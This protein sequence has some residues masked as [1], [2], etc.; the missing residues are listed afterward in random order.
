MDG[1]RRTDP[2][3]PWGAGTAQTGREERRRRRSGHG[4]TARRHT[5]RHPPARPLHPPAP[6]LEALTA[7]EREV[8]VLVARGLSNT[9]ICEY[10]H[11]SSGTVKTHMGR[12]LSKL[13]ARDRA[14]LVISAYE[15]GLVHA[16]RPSAPK[17]G[18]R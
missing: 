3:G 17:P 2:F 13:G 12:L 7:R 9:D 10:L 14:Q 1:A 8:L 5:S 11:L 18:H 15:S 4:T 16:A 6:A